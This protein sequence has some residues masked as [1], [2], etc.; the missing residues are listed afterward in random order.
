MGGFADPLVDL[1]PI[2]SFLSQ[3]GL[4]PVIP[5]DDF[6]KPPPGPRQ[7]VPFAHCRTVSEWH[8]TRYPLNILNIP[9]MMDAKGGDGDGDQDFV[10]LVRKHDL[11][12]A[13]SV[14]QPNRNGLPRCPRCGST[15]VQ[16][17]EAA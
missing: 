11:P 7:W 4:A 16:H 2:A 1:G 8:S 14:L 3:F 13:R 9:A 5:L 12:R 10:L 6:A 15:S 17:I